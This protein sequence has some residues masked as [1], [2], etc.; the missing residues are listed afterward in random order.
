MKTLLL[1]NDNVKLEF[2]TAFDKQEKISP[3]V[4]EMLKEEFDLDTF[5]DNRLANIFKENFDCIFLPFTLNND[6]YLQFTGLLIAAH[7]RL[8]PKYNHLRTPIVFFGSDLPEHVYKLN[9]LGSILFT[10]GIFFLNK[11]DV[12]EKT[13]LETVIS[14]KTM[15]MEAY[16]VFLDRVQIDPP[17]N[18]ASYHSLANEWGIKRMADIFKKEDI[19]EDLLT[20]LIKLEERFETKIYFKFLEAKLDHARKKIQ[21]KK[22][23]IATIPNIEE[24][25]V[26]YI[27]DE[28][29]KG[30]AIMLEYLLSKSKSKL[31]TFSEFKKEYRREDLLND[32]KKF[33]ATPEVKA[34]QVYIIDLRLCDQDIKEKDSSQLTGIQVLS[35]LIDENNGNQVMIFTASNK[36]WNLNKAFECGASSYVLKESPELNYTFDQSKI[37]FDEFSIAIQKAYRKSYLKGFRKFIE[38]AKISGKGALIVDNNFSFK[39]LGN[40]GWLDQLFTLLSL[41]NKVVYK[42]VLVTF[43][44]ILEAYS[45]TVFDDGSEL[46]VKLNN[47]ERK[48]IRDSSLKGIFTFKMGI[49]DFHLFGEQ[50]KIGVDFHPELQ[51]VSTNF[52]PNGYTTLLVKLVSTLHYNYGFNGSRMETIMELVFLRNN[53]AAHGSDNKVNESKRSITMKDVKSMIEILEEMFG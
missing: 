18:Y 31:I 30:W 12:G 27:D 32:L 41:D 38:K 16:R 17:S 50:E 26:V 44:S 49:Y 3:S 19:P 24:T 7:I 40:G 25:T 1:H 2:A 46:A 14:T 36:T 35:H 4:A 9:I 37:L 33:L 5:L 8:S 28:Y 10:P 22:K 20:E 52:K 34:A 15:S 43:I 45:D 21:P 39:L 29:D 42:Q 6:D 23:V 48:I 11:Q 13:T 47:G 51:T 53:I